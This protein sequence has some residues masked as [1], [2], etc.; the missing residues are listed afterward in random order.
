MPVRCASVTPRGLAMCASCTFPPQDRVVVLA[1][2]RGRKSLLNI[3]L[4]PAAGIPIIATNVGGI[5]EIVAGTDHRAGPADDAAGA[6]S[7]LA[8]AIEGAGCCDGAGAPAAATPCAALHV[9]RM[10]RDVVAFYDDRRDA[11]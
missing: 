2:H 6:G 5:P 9:E 8:N 4:G 10:A 7:S 3:V 11:S 1:Y